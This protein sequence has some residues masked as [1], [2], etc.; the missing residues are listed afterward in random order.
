MNR[1]RKSLFLVLAYLLCAGAPHAALAAISITEIFYDAP[2]GDA[3]KEWVEITNTGSSAV[4]LSGLTF[5]EGGVNHK[6]TPLLGGEVLQPGASAVIVQNQKTFTAA[7]PHTTYQLFKSS[8]SLSNTGETI[9]I[10][11]KALAFEDSA[12]FGAGMG[13][14]GDGNALMRVGASFA[15]SAPTPGVYVVGAPTPLPVSAPSTPPQ[16]SAVVSKT[17]ATV[18]V[19]GASRTNPPKATTKPT[20]LH[21]AAASTEVTPVPQVAAAAASEVSFPL[22]IWALSL[23]ALLVLGVASVWYI[24]LYEAA[25]PETPLSADEFE[26]E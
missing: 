10:K 12:T 6:L 24:R 26:V 18:A 7:W 16:E 25:P 3:G 8:F 15:P 4:T 22:D 13:A 21:E 23:G 20:S 2:D 17:R 5:F 9:G 19:S 1:A 11:N 14:A